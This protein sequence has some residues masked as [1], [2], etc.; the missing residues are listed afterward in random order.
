MQLATIYNACNSKDVRRAMFSATFSHDVEEWCQLNL[1][2]VIKIYIGAMYVYH[3]CL[4]VCT[5]IFLHSGQEEMIQ[6][7]IMKLLFHMTKREVPKCC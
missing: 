4:E 6:R 3:I 5:V 1:N 7:R 2:N